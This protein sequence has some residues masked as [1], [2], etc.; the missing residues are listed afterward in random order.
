MS[1]K[2]TIDRVD[3]YTATE[4]LILE[5]GYS[6]FH[7]KALA[8]RL[9]VARSTI[10]NYYDKKEELITDY[11]IHLLAR[12]VERIDDTAHDPEPVKG[13][14]RLWSRYAHIHQMLQ[15]MPYI[16]QEASDKVKENV[17]RMF[18]LFMEMKEKIGVI[19]TTGEEAT[20]IRQDVSL[21]TR[22]GF[23]MATVQIPIQGMTEEEWVD[24]V[25]T[26]LRDGLYTKPTD[27]R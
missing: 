27:T 17:R 16:D 24:E 3:L 8:E 11:M 1:R 7:F 4:E 2:K 15:I 6:S 9:G 10:Y 12:S 14:I 18:Q 13:L 23:I 19:L 26:I 20:K 22:I 21:S 5:E 25:Y